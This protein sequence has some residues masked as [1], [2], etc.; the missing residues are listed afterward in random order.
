M[1]GT[2][3]AA[4]TGGA[5][6]GFDVLEL[7]IADVQSALRSGRVTCRALVDLYLMRIEAYNKQG[8]QLNAVQTLNPN[9]RSEADRLD[10]AYRSSGPAGPLH[11]VPVLMKDQ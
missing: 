9:A 2:G 7:T 8:P 10:A 4:Q 1:Y 11:C 6:S 3:A 5:V